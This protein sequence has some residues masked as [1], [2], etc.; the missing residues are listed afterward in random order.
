MVGRKSEMLGGLVV[1]DAGQGMSTTLIAKFLGDLGAT[2]IRPALAGGDP[3]ADVYPAMRGWRED[4]V[5][6][7]DEASWQD[8]VA[9]ADVVILG[10]EDYPGVTRTGGAAELV[11]KHPR[12]VAL[13]V[14]ALPIGM[15]AEP[16]PS[17]ELLIQARSGLAGTDHQ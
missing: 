13:E 12:L 11:P 10:G 15:S 16:C 8:L 2:V 9:V 4:F 3:F 7:A 17:N 5:E 14:T 6:P 1:V